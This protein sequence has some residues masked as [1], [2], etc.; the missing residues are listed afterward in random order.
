MRRR[1][2]LFSITII[3][4]VAIAV[5]WLA[6]RHHTGSKWHQSLAHT[7]PHDKELRTYDQW[8]KAAAFPYIAPETKRRVEDNYS[9]VE[10]GASKGEVLKAFGPPSFEEEASPKEPNRPC[11]YEFM[12]YFAKPEETDNELTDKRIAVFFTRDGKV[13]WIVGNVGLP[14]K[15]GLAHRP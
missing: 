9:D 13:N 3:L 7:C 6:F 2:Q 1:S 14:E 15:S 4:V 12:Y 10:V 8:R 5:M 11:I